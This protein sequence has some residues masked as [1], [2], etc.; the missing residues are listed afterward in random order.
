M[1]KDI[2]ALL[3]QKL[4]ENNERHQQAKQEVGLNLGN[5]LKRLA[6]H[7]IRPNPYQPRTVFDEKEIAELSQSIQEMGLLQPI[8]V[9]EISGAN[10]DY[11]YEIIAGERRFRAMQLLKKTHIDA[12]MSQKSDADTA[13]LA[14]AENLQRQDLCDYEIGQALRQIENLFPNKSKL[15]EAIGINRQDMYR[16]FAYEALPDQFLEQLKTNPKLISRA[17][18]E[19]IKKVLTKHHINDDFANKVLTEVWEKLSNGEL[20]QS[21]IAH[22]IEQA[23]KPQ[24]FVES[25][26]HIKP[27]FV[28]GQK[29]GQIQHKAKKLVIELDSAFLDENDEALLQNLLDDW[30]SR[31][32]QG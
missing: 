11:Q 23:V 9:R 13:I 24:R 18:A 7:K 14:L 15:A 5:E 17:A 16:Y 19:Q 31:K 27:F 32:N 20:E 10:D 30:L 1:S 6:I 25:Q 26:T 2:K 3:A 28:A 8:S 12:I 29:V 4:A 21:K 22:Y